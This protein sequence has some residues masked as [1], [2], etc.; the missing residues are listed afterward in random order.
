VPTSATISEETLYTFTATATDHDDPPNSLTFSLIGAPAG[1]SIDPTSG[2]FS[3]TPSEAQG[4]GDYTFTVQVSDGDLTDTQAITL[5]VNE[6]NVAPVASNGTATTPE[7]T[8]V[9]IDLLTLVSDVDS[10]TFTFA[11]GNASNGTVILLADGHTAQFTP[12]ANYSGPASFTF[13]ANDGSLD[14]NQATISITVTPSNP[15][16]VALSGSSGAQTDNQTQS[17]TWAATDPDGDLASVHI[18]ITQTVGATTTTVLDSTA[19]SGT[20]DFDALG[21]GTFT[22]TVDATDALGHTTHVT[23]S[24]TVTDDDTAGPAIDLSGS[25]ATSFVWTV[26]DPSSLQSVLVTITKNGQLVQTFTTASG[27]FSF[28][29][30]GAGTYEIQ[31]AAT[32][33]DNDWVGDASSSTASLTAVVSAPPVIQLGG[34]SGAETDNQPQSF[35]WNV[36]DSDGDLA[37]VAVTITKNGQTVFSSTQA[38]GSFDFDALGLGAFEI[39]V[40]A[41]DAAGHVTDATRSVTVTDDDASGPVI[42]ITGS[43]GT[44]STSLTQA[45]T[46]NVTD[47]SGVA[48]VL[49]TITKNGNVVQTFTTASGTFNFDALGPGTYEITVTATDADNDES[50]DAA[51][52]SATRSVTVVEPP[53]P[54]PPPPVVVSPPPP[55]SSP[56]PVSQP[57]PAPLTA[58]LVVKGNDPFTFSSDVALLST[59]GTAPAPLNVL[60]NVPASTLGLADKYLF[61]TST[62]AE[63]LQV[64]ERGWDLGASA[65]EQQNDTPLTRP[66]TLPVRGGSSPLDADDNVGVVEAIRG[67][68]RPRNGVNNPIVP[69]PG[70]NRRPDQGPAPMPEEEQSNAGPEPHRLELV[71]ISAAEASEVASEPEAGLSLLQRLNWWLALPLTAAATLASALVRRRDYPKSHLPPKVDH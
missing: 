44:E 65:S 11:V 3:W 47:P 66:V 62:N 67:G 13:T 28:G 31:V 30:L 29:A 60:L 43:G 34:S 37:S 52:A 14:S 55:S 22:I 42:T 26:S 19:V 39:H 40:V 7:D 38:S 9:T 61:F 69:G 49:V 71:E 8:A 33:G 17:F 18:V 20:E 1:A 41:T 68:Q 48:S 57:T 25:T 23:Q 12:A 46:W 35:S 6:V 63:Q 27:S 32:D 5:H 54:P 24:V 51:T 21:L 16:Q 70:P 36:T 56:T 2:L 50:G 58:F 59:L 45:F 4:P 15:P 64:H 53:Q 10:S